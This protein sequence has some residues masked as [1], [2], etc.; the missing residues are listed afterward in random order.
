MLK[1]NGAKIKVARKNH[2]NLHDVAVD[3]FKKTLL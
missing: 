3:N 2:I 1:K